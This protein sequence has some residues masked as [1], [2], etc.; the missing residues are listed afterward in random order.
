M[1]IDLSSAEVET[2]LESLEYSKLRVREAQG[3]PYP[4][5]QENLA[6]LD[7]VATTLREA[8]KAATAQAK[9]G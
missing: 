9:Q 8:R 5:R 1:M 4:V 6:R 2:L 7:A 3:T